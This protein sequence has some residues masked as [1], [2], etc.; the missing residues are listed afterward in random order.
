M[1]STSIDKKK[2]TLNNEELNKCVLAQLETWIFR[3]HPGEKD[4]NIVYPMTFR[5]D[6]AK[7]MQKKMDQYDKIKTSKEDTDKK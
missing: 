7:N 1:K 3:D 2:S 5:A 4:V 6:P